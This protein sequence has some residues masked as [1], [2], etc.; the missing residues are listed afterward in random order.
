MSFPTSPLT[1]SRQQKA[2]SDPAKTGRERERG[3]GEG[4]G[5][6]ALFGFV[7]DTALFCRS[8]DPCPLARMHTLLPCAA[9]PKGRWRDAPPGPTSVFDT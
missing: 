8:I 5:E 3:G 6:G 2:L 9:D 7:I 1:A 4:W